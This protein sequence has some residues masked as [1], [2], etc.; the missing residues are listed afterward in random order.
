MVDGC[1]DKE[2][3]SD[4]S[5]ILMA[6][7]KGVYEVLNEK[8]TKPIASLASYPQAKESV[9]DDDASIIRVCGFALHSAISL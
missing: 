1:E 9:P 6:V 2:E 3:A 8:V 7:A 4:R 5:A